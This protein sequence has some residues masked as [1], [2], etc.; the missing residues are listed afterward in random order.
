MRPRTNSPLVMIK[1]LWSPS[2][3]GAMP[4][5][6]RVSLITCPRRRRDATA[7]SPTRRT[8]RHCVSASPTIAAR[9]PSRPPG[10]PLVP[11]LTP[12]SMHAFL[13]ANGR[14]HAL[15]AW[16]AVWMGITAYLEEAGCR[17]R[18]LEYRQDE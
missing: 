8:A 6:R 5:G 13:F 2:T 15:K 4:V 18:D 17:H 14:Q 10:L 1:S 11:C 12:Y 3:G 16:M 9:A 7:Q